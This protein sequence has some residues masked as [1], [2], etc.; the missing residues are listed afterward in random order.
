MKKRVK[1]FSLFLT[2]CLYV[3]VPLC[4]AG[5]SDYIQLSAVTHIHSSFSHDGVK[6]LEYWVQEA[7]KAGIDVFI[8]TDTALARWEYGVWPLRGFIKK[9]VEKPSVLS[10]GPDN[11]LNAIEYFRKKYPN[12]LIIPGIEIA[13][14]YYWGGSIWNKRLILKNWNRHMLVIGL[15]RGEDYR[16]LPIVSNQNIGEWNI[17]GVA[18][19]TGLLAIG[20]ILR[21]KSG[22]LTGNVVIA[23]GILAGVYFYP[24]KS[25]DFHPYFND[26]GYKPYQKLIDYVVDRGGLI[27][28]AHPEA[29]NWAKPTGVAP[30]VYIQTKP[31]PEA[32]LNSDNYTGFGYWW[33]GYREVGGTGGYWDEALL[34]Y[35]NGKRKR[36]PLAIAELDIGTDGH[37]DA[38]IN[39]LRMVLWAKAKTKP[40]MLDAM[41]GGR[42]YITSST[43]F[44]LK[45]FYVVT[46]S[47]RV[48]PGEYV[49][50][51]SEVAFHIELISLNKQ[52]TYKINL[53]I[54]RNGKPWKNLEVN[55]PCSLKVR[56][57]SVTKEPA[58]YRLVVTKGTE[59]KLVTNPVF[60]N[61]TK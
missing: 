35:I 61:I 4:L 17:A 55:V 21:K 39:T 41:S 60:V 5:V 32:I 18:L 16:K 22:K 51:V 20:F 53:D 48:Y 52:M 13:P 50:H 1:L 28:W 31:Y 29:P 6:S 44:S 45:E 24:F 38:K 8:P 2:L 56:D 30:G 9:V 3:S 43:D 15:D 33:E 14:S 47:G 36:P 23:I 58:Y 59:C 42:F 25:F 26:P 10:L 12:V 27:F 49:N 46:G 34:Q 57:V 37:S 54:I 11:Y 7:E 19:V 40:D